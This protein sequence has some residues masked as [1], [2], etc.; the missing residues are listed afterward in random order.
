MLVNDPTDEESLRSAVR[1]LLLIYKIIKSASL[2]GG[3]VAKI[4]PDEETSCPDCFLFLL[5]LSFE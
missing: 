5:N 2:R 1:T 3:D 4:I